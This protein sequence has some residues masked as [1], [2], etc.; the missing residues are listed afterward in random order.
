[1]RNLINGIYLIGA[2]MTLAGAAIFITGWQ[3]APYI[4]TVGATLFALGQVNTPLHNSSP[5]LRRLRFQQIIGAFALVFTGYFMLF[6]HHNE[7]IACLAIAA[8]LELYTAFRIPQEEE[9][10]S[11]K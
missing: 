10:A 6:H 5:A 9:K 1:M 4:Y 11:K 8:V 7:W 2:L 3:P